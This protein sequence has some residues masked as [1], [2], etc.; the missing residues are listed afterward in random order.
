MSETRTFKG[1]VTKKGEVQTFGSGFQKR[2]VVICDDDPKYPNEVPF[3]LV[4]DK[5]SMIDGIPLNSVVEVSFNIRGS[6]WEKGQR[7]FVSLNIWK[8]EVLETGDDQP[9]KG[10]KSWEEEDAEHEAATLDTEVDDI[11]F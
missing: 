1:T 3:E 7:H 8:I 10:S 5:V 11:P 2:E 4:K 6:F 9:P